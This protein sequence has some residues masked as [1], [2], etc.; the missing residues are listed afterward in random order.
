MGL[1]FILSQFSEGG[2]GPVDTYILL[3][4]PGG[5]FT[6]SQARLRVASVSF[7]AERAIPPLY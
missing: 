3:Q 1:P 7:G 5:A 2:G 4:V 6:P